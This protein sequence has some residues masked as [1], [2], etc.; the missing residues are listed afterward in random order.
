MSFNGSGFNEIPFDGPEGAPPFVETG[1]G[2]MVAFEQ[3]V[4]LSPP[5][6]TD[7]FSFNTRQLN[8]TPFNA[9]AVIPFEPIYGEGLI[10]S[11]EQTTVIV[12][13]GQMVA[14]EQLVGNY[15]SGEL[16]SIEQD[17]RLFA[18][19]SGLMVSFEQTTNNG[20]GGLLVSFEQTV[21]SAILSH[22]DRTGWDAIIMLGGAQV[23]KGQ[24]FGM[25]DIR[26]NEAGASLATFTILPPRGVQDVESYAGKTVTI[27]LETQE[28]IFRVYTGLVDIPDLDILN[29]RITLSCTD[30]RSELINAQLASV[31]QTIGYS[32]QDIFGIP[33]D[34]FENLTNRL[35]TV[36][37]T[38][39]FDAYGNYNLVP[40]KGK[41][42]PDFTL[43]DNKVYYREPRVEYTSRGRVVNKINITFKYRYERRWHLQRSWSWM[44]P[45]AGN[46]CLAL[47]QGWNFTPRSMIQAAVEA[48]SWPLRDPIVYLPIQPSGWYCGG[49]GFMTYSFSPTG[50]VTSVVEDE[51]GDPVLDSSGNPVTTSSGVFTDVRNVL[52]NGA[53]WTATKR[54]VQTV[55]EDYTLSVASS[56]SQAQYGIVEQFN[57]YAS[58]DDT[59]AGSW[60]DYKAYDNPYNKVE[61]TYYVDVDSTRNSARGSISTAL[62]IAKTTILNSHRDTRVTIN[63]SL[64]P[65]I[66]LKH[67]VEINTGVLRA[68]GKVYT[69]WHSLNVGTGEA[70]TNVVLALSRAVG[71]AVDSSLSIPAKPA[72]VQMP[73]SSEIVLGNHIGLNPVVEEAKLWNGRIGDAAFTPYDVAEQ[74]VVDTPEIEENFRQER[75]LTGSGG[76]NVAIPIDLLEVTF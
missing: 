3:Q 51:N 23:P 68:R 56:Q 17:V 49:V 43:L 66:D 5:I 4:A 47:L 67:T 72:D 52:C 21:K 35:T 12:G 42:V 73:D 37:Y 20:G 46:I 25:I 9:F 10:V 57:S 1:E 65:Q 74:F 63:R 40:L 26:R 76:Y 29:R 55:S 14:F 19:G 36:P 27:D 33:K 32:T 70:V 6:A 53:G 24:I 28:G 39:D 7:G 31:V 41:T 30:R 18:T 75:I 22:V 50:G 58:E 8:Q 62:N 45:I 54:W 71:S 59:G 11:F 15:G 61:T 64:W 2:Q 34:T 13:S 38:V 44:S 16:V 69:I 48:L 60:E